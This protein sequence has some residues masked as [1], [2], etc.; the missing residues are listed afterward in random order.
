MGR[1]PWLAALARV[2]GVSWRWR[3]TV[4]PSNIQ[5]TLATRLHVAKEGC[6][7]EKCTPARGWQKGHS[8]TSRAGVTFK[9]THPRGAGGWQQSFSLLETGC[10]CDSSRNCECDHH[11]DKQGAAHLV[12]H[13]NHLPSP[14]H[15]GVGAGLPPSLCHSGCRHQHAPCT[16]Q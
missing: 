3:P 11:D 1:V 12:S 10:F 13:K 8:G 16:A 5:S 6:E 7:K 9:L 14:P 15:R 4:A 2:S